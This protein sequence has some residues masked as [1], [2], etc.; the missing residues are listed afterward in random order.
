[1]TLR[2]EFVSE[3]NLEDLPVFR[4]FPYSCRYCLYWE[5]A[6]D[7][8]EKVEKLG[9]ERLKRNWFKEMSKTFGNSGAIAYLDDKPVGYVQYALPSAFPRIQQY[10]SGLPSDDS[11]FLACLYIPNRELRGKGIGKHLLDFV[12]SDLKNR[13]YK[14]LETF[15]RKGSESNPTGPMEFYLKQGFTMKRE[16]D[17]FP[18]VRREIDST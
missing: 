14:A 11:V 2:I 17:E 18:L 9:A 6:N 7:F 3:Q 12:V 4:L 15:A 8:D 5:S 16:K 1:M 13:N 10:A